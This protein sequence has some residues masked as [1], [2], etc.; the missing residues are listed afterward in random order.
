M[1][2]ESNYRL[3]ENSP[4]IKAGDANIITAGSN[5]VKLRFDYDGIDRLDGNNPEIGAWEK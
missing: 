4:A 3:K 2:S 1:N 5:L